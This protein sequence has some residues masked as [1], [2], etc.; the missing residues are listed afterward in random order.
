MPWETLLFSSWRPATW[1]L[2]TVF[3]KWN[4]GLGGIEWFSKRTL[5]QE[6]RTFKIAALGT[7][8][9]SLPTFKVKTA[10]PCVSTKNYH[11][12]YEDFVAC[13]TSLGNLNS[14][15]FAN[16]KSTELSIHCTLLVGI[17]VLIT[18]LCNPFLS[19]HHKCK[20]PLEDLS[21][22][23]RAL[24]VPEQARLLP[25]TK[26]TWRINSLFSSLCNQPTFFS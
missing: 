19:V 4:G 23:L 1:C 18:V 10:Q 5:W 21:S 22:R 24:P 14:V 17:Q 13:L 7:K 11:F 12:S 3:P 2:E 8:C 26:V 20:N 9:S 25:L 16:L 15:I 6:S